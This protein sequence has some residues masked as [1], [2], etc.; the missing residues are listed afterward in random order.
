MFICKEVLSKQEVKDVLN[1]LKDLDWAGGRSAAGSKHKNNF[2]ITDPVLSKEVGEKILSNPTIQKFSFIVDMTM[3]RFNKYN[4]KGHYSKHVDFFTQEGVR[5]DLSF[6]LFLHE[7]ETYTGG[8]L[9]VYDS[10]GS[11]TKLKLQAGDMVVYPSGH[12]HEVLPV[13]EGERLAVIGWAQ[14]EVRSSEQLDLLTHLAHAM[15]D[16]EKQY[17]VQSEP[18]I[19]LSAVYNNL[20]K[21][22]S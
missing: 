4:D 15:M 9:V 3:P 1:R 21:M 13:T 16:I 6:T 8:E 19:R 22:W 11:A 2:E 12:I 7:P 5:T 10:M 14:T 17:D 20:I 18:M